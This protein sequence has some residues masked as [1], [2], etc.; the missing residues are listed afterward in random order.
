ME[1][2]HIRAE[3]KSARLESVEKQLEP[4]RI[5]GAGLSAQG[6]LR[7]RDYG[8]HIEQ[9][10]HRDEA[11][12]ELPGFRYA[13]REPVTHPHRLF[14]YFFVVFLSVI[15]FSRYMIYLYYY[16]C[17]IPQLFVVDDGR[18]NNKYTHTHTHTSKPRKKKRIK[19]AQ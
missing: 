5:R 15:F 10:E 19:H 1:R 13:R 7:L 3:T 11:V 12:E 18:P 2:Q 9:D 6:R 17:F 14:F 16:M 4:S 8:G